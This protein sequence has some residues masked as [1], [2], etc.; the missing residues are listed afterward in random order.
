MEMDAILL[1]KLR[2]DGD[3]HMAILGT[4]INVGSISPLS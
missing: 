3:V 1:V 4:Q 2:W